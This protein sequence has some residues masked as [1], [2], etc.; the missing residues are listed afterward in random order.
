M[1]AP[2]WPSTIGRSSGQRPSPSTT[3]RSLWH[4]PV[5][6]VRTSTSRPHGLSISTDSIVSGACVLRKT[7]AF[8]SMALSSPRR[9]PAEPV[10]DRAAHDQLLIAALQPRQLLGEHRHALT[11]RAPHARDVGPP[12]HSRRAERIEDSL[13]LVVDVAERIGLG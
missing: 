3:C 4:T 8:I 1:P 12:E 10:A 13:E 9:V 5:A 6:A 7:A 2:S 11:V